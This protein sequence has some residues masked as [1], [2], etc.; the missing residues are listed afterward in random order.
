VLIADYIPNFFI[1]LKIN[2]YGENY[3]ENDA[4]IYFFL[5]YL[6]LYSLPYYML[7]QIN[8]FTFFR[9]LGKTHLFCKIS[10]LATAT[11]FLF[12][13]FSS[14]ASANE[15]KTD[16]EKKEARQH[17]S[18]PDQV[19]KDAI[20]LWT[21]KESQRKINE[22][23]RRYWDYWNSRQPSRFSGY[24]MWYNLEQT[25]RWLNDPDHN[26]PPPPPP[27][28]PDR[29][30]PYPYPPPYPYLYY[31]PQSWLYNPWYFPSYRYPS[32]FH[33]KK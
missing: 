20:R 4:A 29:F 9:F 3:Y 11:I 1:L 28:L 2:R 7:T 24:R 27:E 25:Q 5:H 31:Y 16:L 17:D 32:R 30:M 14:R 6:N 13:F 21:E 15:E 19:G 26:P 10:I 23:V 33:R 18:Y 22:A 12:F 8:Q